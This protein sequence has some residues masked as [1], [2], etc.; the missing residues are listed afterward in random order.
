MSNK[1]N[2]KDGN[3]KL[4]I[5]KKDV[6]VVSVWG[7]PKRVFKRLSIAIVRHKIG[8][9]FICLIVVIV[10][11]ISFTVYIYFYKDYEYSKTPR[12]SEEYNYQDLSSAE[13]ESRLATDEARKDN[14]QAIATMLQD[15]ANKSNNSKDKSIYLQSIANLELNFG[16]PAQALD[17][18]NQALALDKNALN[19]STVGDCAMILNNYTLAEQS[20]GAAV[21]L[22]T[23]T[24]PDAKS[25]YNNYIY[26]Q[27]QAKAKL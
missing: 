25:D 22:S 15:K 17:Y 3:T 27:N 9:I 13:R 26:L 14:Y 12:Y 11:S 18:A 24:G 1:Q 21:S 16:S 5:D 7:W 4:S 20:Y 10:S 19:Y 23:K 6:V 2:L 8:L